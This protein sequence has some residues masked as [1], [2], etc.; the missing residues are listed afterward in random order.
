M[1]RGETV[2]LCRREVADFPEFGAAWSGGLRFLYRSY[3]RPQ[4]AGPSRPDRGARPHAAR[5]PRERRLA[6]TALHAAVRCARGASPS[7]TAAAAIAFSPSAWPPKKLKDFLIDRKI[8]ADVRDRL[9][10]LVWNGEIVWIAGVEVSERF[11]V[12]APGGRAVRSVV[13]GS[14]MR[15]STPVFTVF[16]ADEIAARILSSATEIRAD[17]GD[18]EVFLLG[19]LKG[20]RSS[21]PTCSAPSPAT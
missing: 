11:K 17:A 13:G 14:R 4:H 16:S 19:I 6:E 3:S 12:T 5:R 15:H 2:V 1:R 7:A 8:A 21:P 9:P 18:A 20:A 10:L